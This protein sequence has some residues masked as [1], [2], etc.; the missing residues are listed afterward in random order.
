MPAVVLVSVKTRLVVPFKAMFDAPKALVKMGLGMTTKV[1]VAVVPVSA[2]G[3]VAET[4]V[5]VLM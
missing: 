2:T 1:A 4:A 5:V 3:P